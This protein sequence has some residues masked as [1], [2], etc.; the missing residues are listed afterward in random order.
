MDKL[1]T[2]C[3]IQRQEDHNS[4]L[5]ELGQYQSNCHPVKPIEETDVGMRATA[6]SVR[7]NRRR[8][9]DEVVRALGPAV[10]PELVGGVL[11]IVPVGPGPVV[12]GV[13]AVLPVRPKIQSAK[14]VAVIEERPVEVVVT[15]TREVVSR[16]GSRVHYSLGTN[17]DPRT[18]LNSLS[19]RHGD[20]VEL[21]MRM[22]VLVRISCIFGEPV[23]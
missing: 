10:G 6:D 2:Q 22:R 4:F 23:E 13:P 9:A 1:A 16:G 11:A 7:E 17:R 8:Q 18:T 20:Y 5:D 14:A 12:E 21:R 19:R 3:K 15:T